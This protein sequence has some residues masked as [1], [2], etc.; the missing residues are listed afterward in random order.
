MDWLAG[1]LTLSM[2]LDL[3]LDQTPPIDIHL[4]APPTTAQLRR[5]DDLIRAGVEQGQVYAKE[6][7]AEA[8]AQRRESGAA[9]RKESLRERHPKP[10]KPNEVELLQ[11]SLKL[12]SS[13]TLQEHTS[14]LFGSNSPGRRDNADNMSNGKPEP[15]FNLPHQTRS[16][17]ACMVCTI[18]LP[19]STF[20]SSGCPN[21][22]TALELIGSPETV[23]ECTSSNFHGTLALMDTERSW[24]GRWQ[25]L[26]G[27]VPGVYAVQVI[28]TLPEE[29]V[30][31]V[32]AAGMRYIPRDGR[33]ED[34]EEAD[35]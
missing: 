17:R 35:M 9:D 30:E 16:L 25:R 23:I 4:A 34:G 2:D 26:E 7:K 32:R 1:D 28:G 18:V 3:D 10:S 29:V 8:V 21:C 19:Q 15:T 33:K 12:L 5:L 31:S 6:K 13:Q 20:L 14:F 24:V 27:Y 11:E 22:E